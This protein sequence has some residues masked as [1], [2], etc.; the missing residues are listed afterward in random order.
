MLP[1]KA[2]DKLGDHSELSENLTVGDS[3]LNMI[4]NIGRK[5]LANFVYKGERLDY[6]SPEMGKKTPLLFKLLGEFQL[7]QKGKRWE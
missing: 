1:K 4:K 7:A 3:F 6:F 5:H 2:F